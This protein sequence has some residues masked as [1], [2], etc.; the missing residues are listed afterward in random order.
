MSDKLDLTKSLRYNS[1]KLRLELIPT[2]ALQE[3]AKVFTYGASKYTVKDAEG[4]VLVDGSDN[5][6]KGQ[7]W[8]SVLA[9]AKRHIESFVSGEDLDPESGALH[10]SH[11]VTN[12][13]FI[14]E[15]YKIYPQGDNRP[16]SYLK[17][18][19][20]GLDLDEV[21]AD[22]I[23]HWNKH[24]GVD[25]I[26]NHWDFDRDMKNKFHQLK[27]NK[28]F[29][30]SIPPKIDPKDIPFEPHC[31]ITSRSI[32]VEW[33]EEWLDKNGFAAKPVYSIGY[34]ESKVEFAKSSGID[35][36]VDDRWENFTELNKA[37]VCCYLFD[38]PHNSRYDVGY[39]RIKSLS[40]LPYC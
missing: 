17:P 38:A 9:S 27:D 30:L 12:L 22:F 37:G 25:S 19:K 3:V 16:H 1:G 29:W 20:I 21:V 8:M 40:E 39:K 6:R 2:H 15:F 7:P 5:W 26:P 4:K 34:G 33:T 23:G 10:L 31:Y 13:L 18:P 24:F 11:A 32:P 14:I 36:F 28:E 35:I